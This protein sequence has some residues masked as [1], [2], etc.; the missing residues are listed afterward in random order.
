MAE[1]AESLSKNYP[2]VHKMI[3]FHSRLMYT[4][5]DFE[6]LFPEILNPR[7]KFLT[8]AEIATI[9]GISNNFDKT[10]IAT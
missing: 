9:E 2:D 8:K 4:L 7:L 3:F 1:A 5:I 10:S 6:S